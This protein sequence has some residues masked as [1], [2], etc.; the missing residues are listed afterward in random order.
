MDAYPKTQWMSLRRLEA[1]LVVL[2]QAPPM[3]VI[4]LLLAPGDSLDDLRPNDRR[5]SQWLHG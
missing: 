3:D 5:Q 2:D 4:T 1:L